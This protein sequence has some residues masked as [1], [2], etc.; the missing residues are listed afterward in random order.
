MAERIVADTN[1]FYYLANGRVNVN[2]F[3]QGREVLCCSPLSIIEIISGMDQESFDRRQNAARAILDSRATILVDPQS[4]LTRDVFGHQLGVET[5]NWMEILQAVAQ[6]PNLESLASGVPDFRQMRVRTVSVDY[7]RQWRETIDTQWRED[8]LDV[9]RDNLANFDEVYAAL[10]AGGRGAPPRLRGDR[11]NRFLAFIN[12]PEWYVE[13]LRALYQRSLHYAAE[14]HNP[15]LGAANVRVIGDF[16]DRLACYMAVYGRYVHRLLVDGAFPQQND[17]G[18]IE[19]FL[20]STSD[21]TVVATAERLW[22]RLAREA[23]Y[24]QRVRLVDLRD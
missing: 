7:L 22:H 3:V 19:L 15:D 16:V 9:L 14:P 10:R 6:S 4:F 1:V 18:D 17:S 20:Y 21:D 23:G 24:E 5:V 12:S 13:Q 8:L 2:Q 11:R